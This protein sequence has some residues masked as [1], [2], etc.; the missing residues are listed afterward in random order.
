MKINL[1]L[2]IYELSFEIICILFH[3]FKNI[4]RKILF[5]RKKKRVRMRTPDNCIFSY[6]FNDHFYSNDCEFF[7]SN[8]CLS[9]IP[10]PQIYTY[11]HTPHLRI[12]CSPLEEPLIQH[13]QN[14]IHIFFLV[15]FF[16][17]F[18][19]WFLSNEI[20][21]RKWCWESQKPGITPESFFSLTSIPNPHQDLFISSLETLLMSVHFRPYLDHWYLPALLEHKGWSQTGVGWWMVGRK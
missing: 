18:L 1:L 14:Y 3:T 19:I 11:T 15:W 2:N 6:D 7:F 9:W 16:F 10:G 5:H 17:F 4:Q 21:L 12:P 20:F 13:F 8:L